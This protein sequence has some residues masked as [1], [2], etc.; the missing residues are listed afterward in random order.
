MKLSEYNVSGV[1][2]KLRKIDPDTKMVAVPKGLRGG[3]SIVDILAQIPDK[4]ESLRSL[5]EQVLGRWQ[6]GLE[7][8]NSGSKTVAQARVSK[9]EMIVGKQTA[10]IHILI[11]F[12]N[13]TG[14]SLFGLL[15]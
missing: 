2:R 5:A 10:Q 11:K 15:S 4:Q 13:K 7:F 8:N 9:L 6:P 1:N 12:L 3:S 14:S